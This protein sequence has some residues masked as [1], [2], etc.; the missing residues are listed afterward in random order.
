MSLVRIIVCVAFLFVLGVGSLASFATAEEPAAAPKVASAKPGAEKPS[1]LGSIRFRNLGPGVETTIPV[2]RH[3]SETY[4]QHDMVEI[5]KGDIAS[6]LKWAPHSPGNTLDVI[7]KSCI[8]R[9]DIW[10]L[11]FT[12]KPMR[13]IWVDVP[14]EGGRLEHKMIYYMVYRVKNP[15]ECMHPVEQKDGKFKIE[16]VDKPPEAKAITFRPLFSLEN[17]DKKK[18]YLDRMI[19]TAIPEIQRREDPNRK[20]LNSIEMSSQPLEVGKNGEDKSAWGVVTWE[21][22]DPTLDKF[23]VVI[24]GLS[25]AQKW[26]DP[27]GAFKA[28]DVPGTGR[29][30]KHKMLMLHFWRPGDEFLADERPIYLGIPG[31]AGPVDFR[32]IYR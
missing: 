26:T 20:L 28:T 29:T 31:N 4:S 24:E 3:E 22:V 17:L 18:A 16:L 12:F 9:K 15:G 1:P 6:K 21:D 19:P 27:E 10:N 8:Y 25:N 5:L 7:C 11:E 2:D 32:W 23:S 14:Q 30:F 13:M